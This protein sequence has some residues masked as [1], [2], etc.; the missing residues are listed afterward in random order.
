MSAEYQAGRNWRIA[1]IAICFATLGF[2]FPSALRDVEE[3][4]V[5]AMATARK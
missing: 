2:V 3:E 4:R 5:A 1:R